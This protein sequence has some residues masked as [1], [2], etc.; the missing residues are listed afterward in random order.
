MQKMSKTSQRSP[1][2]ERE[3]Q[4]MSKTS[5]RSPKDEIK[6]PHKHLVRAFPTQLLA[7][8]QCED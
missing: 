8:G 3:M 1:K 6:P 2:D 4:K 7:W 5:Q